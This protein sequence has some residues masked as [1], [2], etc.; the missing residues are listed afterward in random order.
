MTYLKDFKK[1]IDSNNYQEFLKLW[2]EYCYSEEP[3]GEELIQIL[4]E[5]KSS[6]LAPSF[7][8]HVHRALLLWKLMEESSL[9]DE[10]LK[11]VFDI[12]TTNLDELAELAYEYLVKKYPNDAHFEEKLRLIGL[13]DKEN[14]QGAVRNYEL[15][16]HV[17]KGKYVFHTAGWGTGEILD[18]SLIR[19][20]LTLEFEFVIGPKTLSFKNAIHTLIPLTNDH[21]LSQRFGNPDKLEQEAKDHPLKIIHL[22]LKDLGP[23]TAAEIKD[24]MCE[25]VIPEK[26]WSR[27]WQATR[28]KIKRDT[29]IESPKTQK[30]PFRLLKENVSREEILYKALEAKP[31]ID[32]TIHLVYSFMRDYPETLKNNE[33]KTALKT[34]IQDVIIS[35]KLTDA[36]RLQVYFFLQDLGTDNLEIDEMVKKLPSISVVIDDIKIISFKKR[37]LIITKKV[38]EDWHDIFF[39]LFFSQKQNYLRDYLLSELSKI[40]PES[41]FHEKIKELQARPLTYPYVYVW[42]YQKIFEAKDSKLPFSDSDGNI[43]FF[44]GFLILLDHL[45]HKMEYRDLAKKMVVLVTTNRYKMIRQIFAKANINTVKEFL[46]LSTKCRILTNHDIKII[47]SLAEVVYPALKKGQAKEEEEDVIW[48]TEKGYIATQE[49]MKQIATVET[50]EN[51]KEIEEARSHGDLR[52]NAEYKAALEKRSRLQGELKFLSDQF[53]KAKILLKED[54][55][56]DK[57]MAGTVVTCKGSD[58][59]TIVFTLLGPWEADPEKNVIAFQ[60]KL[61][62]TMK[63]LNIGQAFDFQGIK[64]SV[65]KIENYFEKK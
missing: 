40:K 43:K 63:G 64:Y 45:S 41:I 57:V 47:Q 52:E 53:N 54:I 15:F 37:L 1:I 48:S 56:T 34:K 13:R 7:G 4:L 59:K 23:K 25:L 5:A 18:V 30:L 19:E 10:V 12:Q 46:L 27:W 2:E 38:R 21:F 62:Q 49:R 58:G 3:D 50:L 31:D 42:Y 11:L 20:E 44:E 35:E 36:Q 28:A 29:K 60:S 17:T 55:T 16:T 39:L 22:L 24:E 32:Q 33:I 6:D 61:A 14:F 26:E 9:K 8:K 65:E 51:A